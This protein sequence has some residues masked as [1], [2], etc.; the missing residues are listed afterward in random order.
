MGK[1]IKNIGIGDNIGK[2]YQEYWDLRQYWENISSELG[3][4]TILRKYIEKIG[5][6]IGKSYRAYWE[7]ISS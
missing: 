5:I 4:E 2:I 1:Y 3:L 7:N 6:N